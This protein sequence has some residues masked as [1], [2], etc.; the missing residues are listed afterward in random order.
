MRSP[1]SLFHLHFSY[2]QSFCYVLCCCPSP[3]FGVKLRCIFDQWCEQTA[4]L[5]YITPSFHWQLTS[6]SKLWF[7]LRLCFSLWKSCIIMMHSN[8]HVLA[9]YIFTLLNQSWIHEIADGFLGVKDLQTIWQYNVPLSHVSL[10]SCHNYTRNA[11]AH[12]LP[13][14]AC[15]RKQRAPYW[16]RARSQT[17]CARARRWMTEV[18]IPKRD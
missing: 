3:P 14:N 17:I 6:F 4:R 18:Y 10:Q 12:I 15:V 8:R 5:A 7:N 9:F 11:H 13:A 1:V 16:L 2:P